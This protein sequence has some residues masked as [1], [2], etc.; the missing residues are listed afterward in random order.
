ML[1]RMVR[2]ALA[3]STPGEGEV[4]GGET[5]H[6]IGVRGKEGGLSASGQLGEQLE[7]EMII[8]AEDA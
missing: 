7:R 8:L 4:G 1:L 3:I 5:E 2:F 6:T